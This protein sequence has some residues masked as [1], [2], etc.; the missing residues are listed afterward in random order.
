MSGLQD[1]FAKQLAQLAQI[2][3]ALNAAI[4]VPIPRIEKDRLQAGGTA[5]S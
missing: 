5:P 3:H 2:A 1:A 4:R